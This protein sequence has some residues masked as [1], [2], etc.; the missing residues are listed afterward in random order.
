MDKKLVMPTEIFSRVCGYMRP[1]QSWN[2][3][4]QQEFSERINFDSNILIGG[5]K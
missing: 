4:K 2:K 5:K 1:V 3:G